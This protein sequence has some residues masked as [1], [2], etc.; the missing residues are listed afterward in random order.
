MS[1]YRKLIVAILGAVVLGLQGAMTD[2]SM[3]VAEWVVL[4]AAILNAFGTWLVPETEL[5]A[6]AKTWVNGLVLGAG[7]VV[8]LLPDGLTQQE[9][10]TVA[11]AVLTGAGVL[12]AH[13]H[14]TDI[15]GR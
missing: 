12:A 13:N 5:L 14:P 11:I 10:W 6:T 15:A 7:V 1:N 9:I 3:S 2:G 8:P 4:G